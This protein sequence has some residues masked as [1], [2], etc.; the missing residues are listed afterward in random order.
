MPR[1]R[2]A[3]LAEGC[4]LLGLVAVA[5]PLKHLAGLPLPTRILGPVH[6]LMFLTYA[7][8]LVETA[9]AEAW[10]RRD[11]SRAALACLLPFGTF[12]NDAWLRRRLAGNPTSDA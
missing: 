9:T 6:G 3:G 5:V 8:V 4:T 2:L 11:W 10:P 1:L 12:L 7:M